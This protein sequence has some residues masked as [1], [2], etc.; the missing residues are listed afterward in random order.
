ME[1]SFGLSQRT[2]ALQLL[3]LNLLL[4]LSNDSR[5]LYILASTLCF[6]N[7]KLLSETYVVKSTV[8]NAA[9][10]CSTLT[11]VLRRSCFSENFLN[12]ED[13]YLFKAYN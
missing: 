11:K 12:Q 8:S 7:R 1:V 9:V 5:K 13:I 6:S 2:V 4:V 10:N 3:L